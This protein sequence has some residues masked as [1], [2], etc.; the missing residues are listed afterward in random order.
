M[1][2]FH[3]HFTEIHPVEA[4]LILKERQMNGQDKACGCLS[5]LCKHT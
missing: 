2:N 3:K 4:M 1:T 5:Q